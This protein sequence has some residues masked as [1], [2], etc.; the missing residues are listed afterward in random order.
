MNKYSDRQNLILQK[1]LSIS[2]NYVICIDITHLGAQ[3]ELFLA[4]ELAARTIVGHC[5]SPN[6]ITTQQI[7]QTIETIARQRDFLPKIEIIHSDCGALFLEP[8]FRECLHNLNIFDSKGLSYKNQN[9][10]IERLNRTLKGILRHEMLGKPWDR[11]SSDPLDAKIYSPDEMSEFVQLAIET[12]N[13]KPHKSLFGLSPNHMEEALF[14]KHQNN[15]PS[16]LNL[17]YFNDTSLLAQNLRDY[18]KQVA[19]EYKGD[20]E[21]FFIE[22]RENQEKQYH[23][24]INDISK[25]ADEARERENKISEKYQNLFNAHLEMKKQVEY[26]HQQALLVQQEKEKKEAIKLKK[27][28]AKKLPLRDTIS[29]DEFLFII[30][31]TRGRGY[32]KDRKIFAFV[33]LY[34]TGLRV[35]NLLVLHKRNITELMTKGATTISLI[36]GGAKRFNLILSAKGKHM[37]LEYKENFLSICKNKEENQP[38]FTTVDNPNE[39]IRRDNFDKELNLTLKQVSI[40]LK[41]NIRTHSFRATLITELLKNTSIDDV[42]EVVGHQSISSTLEYKRSRL[43]PFEIKNIHASRS[44]ATKKDKNKVRRPRG[45]W[46]KNLHKTF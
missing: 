3:G 28:L 40:D 12:Y 7:C 31:N 16:Q 10:V 20:W 46:F 26:L 22:W 44:I 42:M 4:I 1:Y 23:K 25:S 5:Y 14:Q 33:L 21:R 45:A 27:Q 43:S 32:T 38:V 36:K 19:L 35:S 34:L 24:I 37:L 17:L 2:N 15:K 29:P 11:I 9:Q 30:E 8:Q 39:P 6:R 13:N 41:K 18:K